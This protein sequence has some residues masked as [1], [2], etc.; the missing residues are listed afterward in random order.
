MQLPLAPQDLSIPRLV[1]RWS[2]YR[3][4][5]QWGFEAEDI[6]FSSKA[7]A[8][9][10]CLFIRAYARQDFKAIRKNARI[11]IFSSLLEVLSLE[12]LPALSESVRP[13]FNWLMASSKS[14]NVL[15]DEIH[16]VGSTYVLLECRTGA[17][18]LSP[19]APFFF[20]Q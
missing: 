3:S 1:A 7:S 2:W 5:C 12:I 11:T 16:S 8:A 4:S 19:D 18:I 6:V 13:L 15:I 20:K 10:D 17:A 14:H 9:S